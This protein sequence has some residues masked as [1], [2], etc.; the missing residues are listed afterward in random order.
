MK[1]GIVGRGTVGAAHHA[2]L[3]GIHDETVCYDKNLP[4]S[5]FED[6]LNTDACLI[7]VPTP[8]SRNGLQIN[9]VTEVLDRLA[10]AGYAGTPIVKSTM[11]LDSTAELD[12]EY[13]GI[14]YNPEFL[15]SNFAIRDV[16]NPE[17]VV[18]AGDES[19]VVE[20]AYDWVD[21]NKFYHVDFQ[22]AEGIK[23]VMNGLAATKVSFVNEMSRILDNAEAVMEIVSKSR[24]F[25]P[26]YLDPM[27]GPYGGDCFPK[28]VRELAGYSELLREVDRINKEVEAVG[29]RQKEDNGNNGDREDS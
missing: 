19:D 28:D 29:S 5:E 6:L 4:S 8:G 2:V 11:P 1:V 22:V 17:F 12:K 13:G 15:R 20:R 26:E 25:S 24:K 14:V 23:L 16:M 3:L 21:T 27:K 7:C 18:A 10:H 9:A